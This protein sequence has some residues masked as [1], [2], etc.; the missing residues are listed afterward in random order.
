MRSYTTKINRKGQ[1]TVPAEL[2]NQLGLSGGDRLV[3]IQSNGSITVTRAQ[4]VVE[5]TAGILKPY[6]KGR[7]QPLTI[8]E[9]KEAAAEGW[10]ERERRWLSER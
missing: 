2:R 6:L 5:Q 4:S 3:W 8:E 9:M 7:N 1:T 10:T